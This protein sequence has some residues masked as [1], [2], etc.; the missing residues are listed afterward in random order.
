MSMPSKKPA[1]SSVGTVEASR[2]KETEKSSAFSEKVPVSC[3]PP[4]SRGEICASYSASRR[5][6][7]AP[8]APESTARHCAASPVRRPVAESDMPPDAAESCAV[9]VPLTSRIS[10]E[11]CASCQVASSDISPPWMPR[12]TEPT[13]SP[14]CEAA[15]W[16]VESVSPRNPSA[17]SDSPLSSAR[18]RAKALS[19]ETASVP[20]APDKAGSSEGKSSA[21]SSSSSGPLMET[22]YWRAG[23]VS[24]RIS[25]STSAAVPVCSAAIQ[26]SSRSCQNC[27]LDSERTSQDASASSVGSAYS[28]SRPSI[29]SKICP[30]WRPMPMAR[31]ASPASRRRYSPPLSWLSVKDRPSSASTSS[32]SS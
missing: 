14:A 21:R 13:S 29:K 4:P 32:P 2:S 10:A 20:A 16:K 11:S 5:K 31:R 25:T 12:L 9:C 19:S 26:P 18:W 8:S 22:A 15:R 7:S 24:P 30:S 17:L 28:P 23:R 3:V 1:V 6:A 27:A